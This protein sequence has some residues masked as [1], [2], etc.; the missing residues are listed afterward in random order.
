MKTKRFAKVML[1][2]LVILLTAGGQ[3]LLA[4]KQE[5]QYNDRSPGYTIIAYYVPTYHAEPRNEKLY[6]PGWTE[7]E[8]IKWARPRFKGHNQPRVPLWGYEDESDPKVMAKK[9]DTAAK[10]GVDVLVFDWYYYDDGPYMW[11]ALDEGFLKATNNDKVKFALM[12]ANHDMPDMWPAKFYESYPNFKV[13]FPGNVTRETFDKIVDEIIEKYFKHP[14]YWLIDGCPYF[15]IYDLDTLVKGLGGLE[16]TKQALNNFRAKTKVA[17]F[18]DLHL[19]VIL[20]QDYILTKGGT[21]VLSEDMNSQSIDDQNELALTFG[22]NSLGSYTWIHHVS[23]PN[24]PQTPYKYVMEKAVEHWNNTA[25]KFNLPY[26]L[27]VTCGWDSTPR[28]CS[29]NMYV[30]SGY[31]YLPTISGNTPE[32]FKNALVKAKEFLDRQGGTNKVL[33]INSWNEWAEGSY[34]E[35]DTVNGFGYLKAINEVFG[36]RE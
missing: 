33:S 5:R 20:R 22:L 1:I 8:V 36:G 26:H 2:W 17:G 14:S 13:L 34:L 6:G 28:V 9:I 10:Y 4:Q 27:N 31:P 15:S 25:E 30:K 18:P 16:K 32:A 11:R 3:T 12:W 7:W 21:L 19:N 23:L 29:T 24:F 35:P